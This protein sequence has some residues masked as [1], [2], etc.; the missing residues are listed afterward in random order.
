[1]DI[2]LIQL[3]AGIGLSGTIALA[4]WYKGALTKSGLAAA[5][6]AG[7]II[8]TLGNCLFWL[9]MIV[10]FLTSSLLGRI[11]N[12]HKKQAAR[13]FAKGGRRDWLQVAANGGI[14]LVMVLAFHISGQTVF[15]VGYIAAFATVNAD[16]WATE[17]G[18]LNSRPPLFIL[19]MK[20]TL[21][22][23]SGAVSMLGTGAAFCGA[24]FIAFTAWLGFTL[25]PKDIQL[26]VMAVATVSG[27]FAGALIDSLL[28][29]TVQAMHR[30]QVCG[31]LTERKLHHGQ[32]A[33]L[34][35]G[36]G[37]FNNDAVNLFSSLTGALLAMGI[38][39]IFST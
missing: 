27:G 29:A 4:A 39:L 1:M 36:W 9:V 21:P 32:A 6:V 20:P 15:A 24:A 31:R 37:W 23:A 8:Y 35:R 2:E 12:R 22:G 3:L 18:T 33:P 30:C 26:L 14:G 11:S 28:G 10:F 13:E 7:T 16:T 17:I 5:T 19:T 34:V 25:N 38:Y